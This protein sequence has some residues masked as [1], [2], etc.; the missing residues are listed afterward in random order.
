MLVDGAVGGVAIADGVAAVSK[1]AFGVGRFESGVQV[2]PAVDDET[3]L[4][5]LLLFDPPQLGGQIL[6]GVKGVQSSGLLG[7]KG[8]VGVHE[9]EAFLF[10]G[11]CNQIGVADGEVSRHLQGLLVV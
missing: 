7:G 4:Q 8:L 3:W 1:L 2:P 9:R 10:D 6:E 11:D 5:L